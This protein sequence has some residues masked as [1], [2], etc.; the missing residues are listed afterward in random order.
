MDIIQEQEISYDDFTRVLMCVGTIV[1]AASAEWA[2]G[3][4]IKPLDA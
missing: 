4:L 3:A 1:A 2:A